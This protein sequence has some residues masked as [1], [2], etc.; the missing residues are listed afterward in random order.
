MKKILVAASVLLMSATATFAHNTNISDNTKKTKAE[1]KEL[2]KES[3]SEVSTFTRAQFYQD[4]PDAKDARF[5]K[6]ANFDEVSFASG[7]GR[8][9]AYY[10]VRSNLVGTTQR[11]AFTDL[12]E[13]AQNTIHKKY[14]DYKIDRI[15]RYDDNESNDTDMTMF[16]TA[17]DD[18]DNYFVEL[19]KDSELTIVKVDMAG[20]VSFF[21]SLK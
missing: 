15:F 14:A 10:D 7:N 16:D 21:K 19:R 12:P 8:I 1:R 9:R 4:F 17:F 6:T 3:K 11:K 2:R 18:A 20:N 13:N 5:E